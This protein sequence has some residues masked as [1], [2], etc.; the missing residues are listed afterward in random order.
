[1]NLNFVQTPEGKLGDLLRAG[2]CIVQDPT[3]VYYM[4]DLDGRMQDEFFRVQVSVDC[5]AQDHPYFTKNGLIEF[6]LRNGASEWR[7]LSF[8]AT[9]LSKYA[10][11]EWFSKDEPAEAAV[12]SLVREAV[13]PAAVKGSNVDDIVKAIELRNKGD[14]SGP[15]ID[16]ARIKDNAQLFSRIFMGSEGR[17]PPSEM[18]EFLRHAGPMAITLSDDGVVSSAAFLSVQARKM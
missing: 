13:W 14:L 3:Y 10:P 8:F 11:D 15:E 12:F 16:K 18:V 4:P 17:I 2:G 9:R 5:K 1:V 6:D 7:P